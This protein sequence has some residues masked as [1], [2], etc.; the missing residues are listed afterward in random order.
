MARI[1][2]VIGLGVAAAMLAT[3]M[4]AMARPGHGWGY[5]RPGYGHGGGY[6]HHRGNG[7]DFGDFLLGAVVAGGIAAVATNGFGTRDSNRDDGDADWNGDRG[8]GQADDRAD[9][10]A[11]DEAADACAAAAER[12]AG[13]IST[14]ARVTDISRVSRDGEGWQVQGVVETGPAAADRRSF[15]CGARAGQVDFVQLGNELAIR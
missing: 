10:A 7:F 11:Q 3:S 8:R 13:R 2:A 14:D 4:P 12:Q 15:L 6:R 1:K 9:T 5:P